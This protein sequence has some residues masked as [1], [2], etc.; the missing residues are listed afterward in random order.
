ME[1]LKKIR[2]RAKMGMDSKRF[3]FIQEKKKIETCVFF[4]GFFYATMRLLKNINHLYL[5]LEAPQTFVSN[6]NLVISIHVFRFFYK[7]IKTR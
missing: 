2:P 5:K 6:K 7:N 4:R 3:E 1:L